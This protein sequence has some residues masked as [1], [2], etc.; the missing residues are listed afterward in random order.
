MSKRG[1]HE[2]SQAHDI[3][4]RNVRHEEIVRDY[5]RGDP[6]NEVAARY[7]IAPATVGNIRRLYDLPKRKPGCDPDVIAAVLEDY[8]AG[9]PVTEIRKTRNV[10]RKTIWSLCRKHNVPMRYAARSSL[11]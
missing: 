2:L 3:R 5:M 10:D 6:I 7:D 1:E 11:A 4:R 9:I 8:K